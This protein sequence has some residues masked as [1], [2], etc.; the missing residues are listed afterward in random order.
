[1]PPSPT[2]S[3]FVGSNGADRRPVIGLTTYSEVAGYGVW[4]HE[5]VLLPRTYPDAVRAAGGVPV[6]LP[7][8]GPAEPELLAGIDALV[9]T[10]GAD[11]DPARYGQDPHPAAESTRPERD[12]AELGLLHAAL[13]RDLPVL[14]ICRG[15]QVLN[16]ALGGT[17]VQHV[18][19]RVGH[20]GHRPA[21][22]SFGECAVE[23]DPGATLTGLLGA[24]ALVHCHH[25]QALDS[26]GAGLEVVGRA[27]DGTA[28]AVELLGRDFVLGV[29]WHPEQD[30][31]LAGAPDDA[32]VRI[33]TGLVTAARER[34][35]QETR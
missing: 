22:G 19:E 8:Y 32:G 1:M 31:L 11:V 29:Q 2:R 4:R 14:G 27:A 5:A 26:L 35:L 17:L 15:L 24:T 28:E 20:D 7:S 30:H 13:E 25:H 33:F 6:L 10:G 9:L 18:P 21:L 16:V 23:L 34:H 12:E 3:G